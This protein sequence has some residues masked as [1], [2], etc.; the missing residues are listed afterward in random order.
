ML[1][2]DNRKTAG[3]IARQLGL[4][5]FQAELEPKNKQEI[6][7]KFQRD[8]AVVM[9]AGDGINDAPA[10]AHAEVWVAMGT[11]TDVAIESA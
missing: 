9:M 8:G 11:G 1:T 7:K 3:V 6:V 2:G 5:D 4:D 10:L